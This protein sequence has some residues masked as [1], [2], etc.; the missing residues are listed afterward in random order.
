MVDEGLRHVYRLKITEC[1]I[2]LVFDSND[3]DMVYARL[4]R[5]YSFVEELYVKNSGIEEVLREETHAAI[6]FGEVEVAKKHNDAANEARSLTES[7]LQRMIMIKQSL[8]VL[9]L[10]RVVD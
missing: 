6:E 4:G 9:E 8:D 3:I 1:G 10:E 2:D 7:Q 5:V